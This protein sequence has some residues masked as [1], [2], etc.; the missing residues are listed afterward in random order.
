MSQEERFCQPIMYKNEPVSPISKVQT[1]K[2]IF[3]QDDDIPEVNPISTTFVTV[4][5]KLQ[6][7]E[8]WKNMLGF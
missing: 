3:L 1:V 8:G 7:I 6:K 4:K 5:L 2:P